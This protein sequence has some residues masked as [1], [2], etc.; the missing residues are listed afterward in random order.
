MSSHKPDQPTPAAPL[1]PADL[2][3]HRAYLP[4]RVNEMLDFIGAEATATLLNT[5]SGKSLCVPQ[6]ITRQGRQ[7]RDAIA[8][9]LGKT[10][11]DRFC[12]FATGYSRF[13]LIPR[14]EALRRHLRHQ[15]IIAEFDRLTTGSAAITANAATN[16]L[17]EQH[18]YSYRSIYR[19][20]KQ[21]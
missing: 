12:A 2:L 7:G 13:F 4:R 18:G 5:Y 3:A 9:L 21:G 6:G 16:L 10:A 19:I 15:R 11:A 14:C 1:T 17:A 20:L 8:Q